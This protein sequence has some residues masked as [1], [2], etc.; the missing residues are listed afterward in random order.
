MKP[1]TDEELLAIF[2]EA[3]RLFTDPD[4]G[5]IVGATSDGDKHCQIAATVIIG[6]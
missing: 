6:A 1:K 5:P 4:G 2:T 3:R